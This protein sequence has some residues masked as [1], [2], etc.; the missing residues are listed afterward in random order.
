MSLTKCGIFKLVDAARVTV[1][2]SVGSCAWC[3]TTLGSPM[4]GGYVKCN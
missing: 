4:G 2:A 3:Y 1:I